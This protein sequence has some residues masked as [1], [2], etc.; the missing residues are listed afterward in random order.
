MKDYESRIDA[1]QQFKRKFR[2]KTATEW[3]DRAQF[4]PQP[5]KY[6]IVGVVG[7]GQTGNINADVEKLNQRNQ[8]ISARIRSVKST[9]TP[10]IYELMS[11]IWDI[12]RMNRTL[13][14]LD[15]DT[16]KNPLGRLTSDSI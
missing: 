2:D 8:I 13:K 3:D 15:F 11:Q 14:E 10:E 1:I 4:K 7:T 12:N 5:G 16:E 9:L 6:S